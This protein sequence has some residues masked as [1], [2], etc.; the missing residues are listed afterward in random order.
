MSYTACMVEW[1]RG[2]GT[3]ENK[4]RE[5]GGKRQN[6]MRESCEGGRQVKNDEHKVFLMTF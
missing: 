6:G 3:P 4:G 1:A 5:V 2:A